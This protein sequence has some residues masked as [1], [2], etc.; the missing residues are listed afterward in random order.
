MTV[1]ADARAARAAGGWLLLWDIDGTLLLR[2]SRAH[3][4]AVWAALL[5]VHGLDRD[6]LE[7]R[8]GAGPKGA[9]MT[10]GQIARLLLEAAGVDAAEIDAHA[11]RVRARTCEL[12]APDDL[13]AHLNPGVDALLAELHERDD[14]VQTLVTGNF[15]PVARRKLEAAGIGRWFDATLGGGFGSDHEVRDHLPAIARTRVGAALRDDGAP[16]PAERTIVIGDTPRDIA[17]ARH[18]GVGVIAVATGPHAVDELADAD[19]VAEDVATLRDVLLA[20]LDAPA[21]R[22]PTGSPSTA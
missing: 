21:D 15:E 10:D 7:T 18:D 9:G 11:S 22:P 3:A 14:V 5:E 1:L 17:C 16:W 4:E 20:R 2:A 8:T 12:Y 19:A 6:A 13:T